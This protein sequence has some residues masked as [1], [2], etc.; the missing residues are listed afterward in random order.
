MKPT[1]CCTIAAALAATCCPVADAQTR[2]RADVE[3]GGWVMVGQPGFVMG[4]T[5]WVND[6][7]GVVVR[8]F[9]VPG[10]TITGGNF[11]GFETLYHYRRFVGDFEI[12][13]GAGLM[14]LTGQESAVARSPTVPRDRWSGW[15]PRTDVLVGR[16]LLGRLGV[17][18]GLGARTFIDDE[19]YIATFTIVILLGNQ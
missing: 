6:H 12:N 17:K 10:F 16:R 5:G 3:F 14:Y 7:S 11:R 9:V 15:I 13:L 19:D 18:A 1:V 8:G 4:A 2:S